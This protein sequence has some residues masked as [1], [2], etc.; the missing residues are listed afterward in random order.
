MDIQS[1]KDDG[2]PM[3]DGTEPALKS[4][5]SS[6]T[7]RRSPAPTYIEEAQKCPLLSGDLV[8]PLPPVKAVDASKN[9]GRWR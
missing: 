1:L 8:R 7:S 4:G 9:D 6:Q 3:A 5:I 2:G